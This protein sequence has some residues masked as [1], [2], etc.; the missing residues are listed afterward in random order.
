MILC[1]CN[2]IR[3]LYGDIMRKRILIIS[4][5]IFAVIIFWSTKLI[6]KNINNNVPTENTDTEPTEITTPIEITKPIEILDI[7]G[8]EKG[9]IRNGENPAYP[10]DI[11]TYI[12][13]NDH[14]VHPSVIYDES[15]E[16]EYLWI[17]AFTPYSFMNDYTENPSIVVSENGVDWFLPY[18]LTNPI[19]GRFVEWSTHYSD[20]E[21]IKNGDTIELWYRQSDKRKKLSRILRKV[22]TNLIDW[23]DEEVIFEYGT[24]GYGFGA[25]T[26]VLLNGEYNIYYKTDMYINND[27]Y[28][29]RK[30]K[31]LIHWTDPVT[32]NFEYGEEWENFNAWHVEI[33]YINGKYYS[34]NMAYPNIEGTDAV[35]FAFDSEDGINFRNPVKVIE[36]TEFGFD[37][38]NIYKS[39]FAIKDEN[40]WLFYSAF[41]DRKE[42]Y[43]GLLIGP[44]FMDLIPINGPARD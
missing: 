30:S 11:P 39:S 14:A 13:G 44:N 25:P 6:D 29:L 2:Y 37:N 7:M 8:S 26:I 19:V 22:S 4:I 28:V 3:K 32:V 21:I 15:R 24:G 1:I 42:S 9:N 40:I 23:S 41:N 17:M 12:R 5:I 38:K 33:R 34:L 16:F 31:D 43:I 35:L 18:G 36:P 20:P 27:L 10:L